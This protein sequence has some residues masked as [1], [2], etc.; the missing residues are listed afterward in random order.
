MTFVNLLAV[1]ATI[2][3]VLEYV[4]LQSQLHPSSSYQMSTTVRADNFYPF[5]PKA[6]ILKPFNCPGKST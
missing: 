6:F 1:V 2:A 5:H 3:F 4:T